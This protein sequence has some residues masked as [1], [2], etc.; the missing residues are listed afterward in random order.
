MSDVNLA[1]F[2]RLLLFLSGAVVAHFTSPVRRA[3][4]TALFVDLHLAGVVVFIHILARRG[5]IEHGAE[6]VA[7]IYSIKPIICWCRIRACVI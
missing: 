6:A 1:Q 3:L 7:A 4:E 2:G 5:G